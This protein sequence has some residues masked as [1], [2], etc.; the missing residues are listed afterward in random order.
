MKIQNKLPFKEGDTF[1]TLSHKISN[2]KLGPCFVRKMKISKIEYASPD[3]VLIVGDDKM[4]Y[5]L[6]EVLFDEERAIKTAQEINKSWRL[7]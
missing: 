2:G 5:T 7:N 1:Y 3:E 4:V 6:N